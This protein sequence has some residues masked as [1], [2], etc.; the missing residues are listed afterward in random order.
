MEAEARM[1]LPYAVALGLALLAASVGRAQAEEFGLRDPEYPTFT[2]AHW[3]LHQQPSRISND[4]WRAEL[5]ALADAGDPEAQYLVGRKQEAAEGGYVYALEELGLDHFR[6]GQYD[7]AFRMLLGAAQMGLR[8]PVTEALAEMYDQGWGTP[9]D[10][11]K[12]CYWRQYGCGRP[13]RVDPLS[14]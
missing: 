12:A 14:T 7:A 3:H 2:W 8:G 13:S 6:R 10:H 1:R 11:L 9:V 4:E 5:M